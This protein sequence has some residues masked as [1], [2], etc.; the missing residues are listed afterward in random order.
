MLKQA[1]AVFIIA[2]IVTCFASCGKMYHCHCTY[3]TANGLNKEPDV[4]DYPVTKKIATENCVE[5]DTYAKKIWGPSSHCEL[6]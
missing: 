4:T 6:K 5:D 1:C 2:A 3:D